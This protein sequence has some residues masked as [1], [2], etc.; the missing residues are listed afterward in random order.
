MQSCVGFPM[1]KHLI[2]LLNSWISSQ[3]ILNFHFWNSATLKAILKTFN[4]RHQRLNVFILM[5]KY[6]HKIEWPEATQ[7]WKKISKGT[8]LSDVTQRGGSWE[9][10]SIIILV[11]NTRQ[12]WLFKETLD[13]NDL[14]HKRKIGV[15]SHIDRFWLK[16]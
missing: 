4:I 10:I 16:P 12:D 2:G 7:K 5:A 6:K 8:F 14:F 3:Y 9:F 11:Q 1:L 13:Y 15:A